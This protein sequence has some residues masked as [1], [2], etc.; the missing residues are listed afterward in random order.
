MTFL[1]QTAQRI[2][3]T[4]GPSL[5]D[6][7]VILPTRRAVS[8]FLDELA[9]LSDRPFLAPHTLAVD[10]FITQSAGVQLIDSV[11]LLFELYEVFRE[12]DP[13]VEFEQFIGWASV[14]LADFDRIDQYRIDTHE[15]FSYL[16]AAK[17]LERW[18]VDMPASAKP[19]VETPGTSRYFRLFENLHTA[20]HALHQRLTAQNMAYRGM[21]YRLLADNVESLIRD[22]TAY[23]RV[24]FVGFNALSAAEEHI[25][26]V[27]VDAQKA[28]LFWDADP[29]YLDDTRQEAGDFLRRY[30]DNGWMLSR[31]NKENIRY[32]F[33]NLLGTEKNI[34]VVGV[35][36][37]S[38][39][40]K[41]AGKIH[42][43]WSE[44]DK[45]PGGNRSGKTAI[46]LADETLLV[47]V[48]YALDENVTDLNVTMGLSLRSSLLFTLVDTLFEMQRTVHEFRT[49]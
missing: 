31:D 19:I 24:Y 21:A 35:P 33:N 48:L 27:L 3:D 10:D 36:N 16:T 37:A 15:L 17:A 14:L 34:R 32:E 42:Q 41:V 9:A 43:E 5:S 20:Y 29:Y 45:A 6:V 23:E 1:Q 46:V 7:W 40:A 47:P 4:H 13:L 18:Q 25:I 12:I 39:Q 26:R 28:E 38:M 44:L 22:N 2:F 8:V 49:K 11:S 30:R